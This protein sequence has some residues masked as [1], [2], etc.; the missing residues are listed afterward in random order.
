[1]SDVLYIGNDEY[2]E[3]QPKSES[4]QPQNELAGDSQR[5]C[6]S[7]K[8][9]DTESGFIFRDGKSLAVPISERGIT[10]LAETPGSTE[11][12][13]VTFDCEYDLEAYLED[14]SR[15]MRKG[16]F[17]A[18]IDLFKSCPSDLR[19]HPEFV[20]DFV[21]ALLKQGAY[22]TLMDFAAGKE[23]ILLK[24][25]SD[26]GQIP[27]QYLRS[28]FELGRQR[29]FRYLPDGDMKDAGADEAQLDLLTNFESLDSIQVQLLCNIVQLDSE[30]MK[31]TKLPEIIPRN[32][33]SII[34]SSS[35]WHSLYK[36]LLSTNRIWDMRDLFQALCSR[37]G[38]GDAIKLLFKNR[39]QDRSKKAPKSDES[40][41]S[42]WFHFVFDWTQRSHG[43]E[44]TDLALLD[45][46][47]TIFLQLLSHSSQ[48]DS[49]ITKI[50]NQAMAHA[51]QF[52]ISLSLSNPENVQTSPYLKWALANQ[53]LARELPSNPRVI[54][55]IS[56]LPIYVPLD[57]HDLSPVHWK[58]QS[59][60][61]PE[62][63]LKLG[64]EVSRKNGNYS[65]IVKYLQEIFFTSESPSEVL[66][67]LSHIQEDLQGD[68]IGYLQTCLT[69]YLF[70][71]DKPAMEDLSNEIN[72]FDEKIQEL[73]F[74]PRKIDPLTRWSQRGIQAALHERLRR[75]KLS[76]NSYFEEQE[77][78]YR[79]LLY[80]FKS[81]L[82]ELG[83][84]HA[85]SKDFKKRCKGTIYRDQNFI[86]CDSS[87]Y[88]TRIF[89]E[90][91]HEEVLIEI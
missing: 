76:T 4:S 91:S 16:R 29:A 73:D 5:D 36:H 59:R 47:V 28:V 66:D 83:K 86:V 90:P 19:D 87:G 45:V 49:S 40:E 63:L 15:L 25:L 1:M 58:R 7:T 23:S 74:N 44:S 35:N 42:G 72:K 79:E 53:R 77:S 38:V 60:S 85:L 55:F 41:F 70:A 54:I 22:K 48:I 65:L 6:P 31:Y 11:S 27:I 24:Q 10:N 39:K 32:P 67:E 84:E 68:N 21:D 37:Y 8:E 88:F 30:L 89:E 62:N 34:D 18:A 13:E 3:R 69:K 12:M 50:I 64:L 57:S 52:T 71:S 43:D 14:F 26:C 56:N 2:T 82:A 33:E 75:D 46:L 9:D 78:A 20:L 61:T 17:D 81:L 80:D 51:N